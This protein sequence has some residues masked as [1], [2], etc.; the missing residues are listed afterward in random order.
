MTQR[1]VRT[2]AAL[3]IGNELLSG[4]IRD[5]NV[6][7]LARALRGLGIRLARV[8]MLPD[9]IE[10]LASEVRALSANFDV[11]FTS[12]GVGPTHDDVTVEAVALAFGVPVVMDPKLSERCGGARRRS[13]AERCSCASKSRS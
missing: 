11:V 12:G 13:S 2:A 1:I 6:S 10:I 8:V 4:K 3:V 9:D 5:A 7:E